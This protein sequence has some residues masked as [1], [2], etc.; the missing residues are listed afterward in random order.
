MTVPRTSTSFGSQ[1]AQNYGSINNQIHLAPS[2]LSQDAPRFSTLRRCTFAHSDRTE[3]ATLPSS[4]V[5]FRRDPVFVERSDLLQRLHQQLSAP[6][7]RVALVGLGGVGKSQLAIECSY[8]T[9]KSHSDTWVLWIYAGSAAR[10]EQ[11]IREVAERMKV[12]GR[13]GRDADIYQLVR[14]WLADVKHG[15]RKI[16]LDNADDVSILD[17]RRALTTLADIHVRRAGAGMD[18][19]RTFC[20]AQQQRLVRPDEE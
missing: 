18:R 9:R 17:A 2:R 7:A 6:A 10:F 15:W 11:G 12:R 8:L 14:S 19:A 1:V 13:H 20:Q 3:T 5:P 4:N 16:I